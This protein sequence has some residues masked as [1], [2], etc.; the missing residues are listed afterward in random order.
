V[1]LVVGATGQVGFAVLRGL[2]ERGKPVTAMLRSSTDAGAVA[3]TGAEVVRGDLRDPASLGPACKGAECVV[4]NDP[5]LGGGRPRRR[6]LVGD[7]RGGILPNRLVPV[8]APG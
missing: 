7:A 8:G 5:Q 4:V 1:I 2:R 6:Q 3:A